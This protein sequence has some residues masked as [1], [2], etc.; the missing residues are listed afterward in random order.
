MSKTNKFLIF[1]LIFVFFSAPII[2]DDFTIIADNVQNF[3]VPMF[4]KNST[5]QDFL[6]T[7][8]FVVDF[9]K[10]PDLFF[11]YTDGNLI[12]CKPNNPK[13]VRNGTDL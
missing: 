3:I 8:Y 11:I 10:F 5:L 4:S 1:Y 9:P 2:A 7:F 12:Y 6:D 13:F